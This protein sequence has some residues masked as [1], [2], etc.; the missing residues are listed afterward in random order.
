MA[1]WVYILE[2]ADGSYYV[3]HCDELEV[4]LRQH[5]SG[6]L[7]GYTSTRRPV[8]LAYSQDFPTRDEA[9][10]AERQIKGRTRRKKDALIRGDWEELRLL[11]RGRQRGSAHPSTGSG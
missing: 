2:C 5:Q 8:R 3:G 4:R 1:F 10:A 11:A 7:G 6:A 9:F